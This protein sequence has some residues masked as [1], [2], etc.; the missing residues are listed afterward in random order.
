M[1]TI[2][3]SVTRWKNILLN[4]LFRQKNLNCPEYWD[5]LKS[6]TFRDF[7]RFRDFLKKGCL[8][9]KLLKVCWL[10]NF[11][12]AFYSDTNEK[13]FCC[14]CSLISREL[15]A[16]NSL[17]SL[18]TSIFCSILVASKRLLMLLATNSHETSDAFFNSL[19]SRR[20]VKTRSSKLSVSVTISGLGSS[21]SLSQ[22]SSE[23]SS[24]LLWRLESKSAAGIMSALLLLWMAIESVVSIDVFQWVSQNAICCC[25]M[26][27]I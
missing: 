16:L 5:I 26:C 15:S 24:K 20:K 9:T 18:S 19:S 21:S 10:K 6:M 7:L 4:I 17:K 3:F 14:R 2:T 8:A 13:R 22:V 11:S 1:S 12:K 25:V 23:S 27:F